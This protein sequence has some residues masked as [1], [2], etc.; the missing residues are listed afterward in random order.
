MFT[1][2][3]QFT[4]HSIGAE[5]YQS[6]VLLYIQDPES[7]AIGSPTKDKELFKGSPKFK[8][9]FEMAA[10]GISLAVTQVRGLGAF[11]L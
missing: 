11:P 5:N 9:S 8:A 1:N 4:G 7:L 10:M 3:S 2:S 6:Q